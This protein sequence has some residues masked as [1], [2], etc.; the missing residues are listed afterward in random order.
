MKA[1]VWQRNLPDLPAFPTLCGDLSCEA[2][3]VGAGMTGLL[4]AFALRN[5][6][7]NVVV[8]ESR[9]PGCGVTGTSSAHI[10]LQ[11]HLLFRHLLDT[12]GLDLAKQYLYQQQRAIEAYE[13]LTEQLP[14]SCDFH[15][16]P[17][18]LFHSRSQQSLQ[19]E[20][21][22]IRLTG[23]PAYLVEKTELPFPVTG[24]ICLPNQAC[25]HPLQFLYA[26]VPHLQ[27][28][29]HTPVRHVQNGILCT[30]Q[31]RVRAKH[32]VITAHLPV[33]SLPDRHVQ[34]L[35]QQRISLL[36][37]ENVLSLTGLYRDLALSGLMLRPYAGGILL[38]GNQDSYVPSA[39]PSEHP[40]LRR[41]AEAWWPGC[42]ISAA[43][44]SQGWF[45]REG[46]PYVGAYES[47][48]ATLYMAAGFSRFGMTAAM[49]AAHSIC[50]RI[51]ESS[52]NR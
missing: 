22:A 6:G 49:T 45:T 41:E 15:R 43:W 37:V 44:T 23:I 52:R 32:I 20:W 29:A 14:A 11:N 35:R 19:R 25:F 50:R 5:A 34:R 33:S 38:S 26:L 21:E 42:Q 17:V 28:F 8:L 46:L 47:A 12:L 27:I 51:V 2:A 10:T 30:D 13:A 1:S 48:R 39:L 16:V 24:A 40:V 3:V 36:A 7:I 9:L 4:T 31:G 18:Y